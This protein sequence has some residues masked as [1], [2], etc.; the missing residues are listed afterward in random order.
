MKLSIRLPDEEPSIE[1]KINNL[2][3]L[4][5]F[6]NIHNMNFFNKAAV[7]TP[8]PRRPRIRL[9]KLGVQ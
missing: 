3:K 1:Q 9:R 2:H 5:Y 8:R 6:A 7:T 4:N